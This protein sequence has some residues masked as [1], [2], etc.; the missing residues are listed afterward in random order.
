MLKDVGRTEGFG[1]N[2]TDLKIS[3]S[4]S[5][6][7]SPNVFSEWKRQVLPNIVMTGELDSINLFKLLSL[8]ILSGN[9]TL[10]S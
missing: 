2:L 3:S 1:R 8:S 6:S 5:A 10:R 9:L 4:F 7:E